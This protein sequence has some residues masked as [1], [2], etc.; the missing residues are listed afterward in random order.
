MISESSRVQQSPVKSSRDLIQTDQQA[1]GFPD[2][3]ILKS[4]FCV[5]LI[6]QQVEINSNITELSWS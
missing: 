6:E 4:V 1:F 3:L 5:T 2:D